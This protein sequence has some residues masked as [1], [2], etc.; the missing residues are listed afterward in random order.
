MGQFSA[1]H[2]ARVTKVQL[3]AYSPVFNPIE[4][5]WKNV[6]KLATH[7]KYFPKFMLIQ[8]AVDKALLHFA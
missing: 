6:K 3:P 8:T 4:Y 5:L 7:L 2:T 1:T